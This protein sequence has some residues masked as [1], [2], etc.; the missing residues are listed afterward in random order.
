MANSR[1]RPGR[2]AERE[3]SSGV[4]SP[5]PPSGE[6]AVRG[7]SGR[8]LVPPARNG[9][10]LDLAGNL[11]PAFHRQT[12]WRQPCGAKAC[13]DQPGYPCMTCSNYWAGWERAQ[14]DGWHASISAAELQAR[15]NRPREVGAMIDLVCG[16][17]GKR[18]LDRLFANPDFPEAQTVWG[19]RYWC[20]N[21]RRPCAISGPG[22]LTSRAVARL[23]CRRSGVSGRGAPLPSGH[24]IPGGAVR[25]GMAAAARAAWG[26]VR[27]RVRG[28]AAPY[29]PRGGP[30]EAPDRQAYVLLPRSPLGPPWG[31][32]RAVSSGQPRCP[33]ESQIRS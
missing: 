1:E 28:W 17:C 8:A 6:A 14:P 16:G 18:S 32:D 2:L 33:T 23:R 4:T 26:S 3:A 12:E 20:G 7:S 10:G 13:W 25:C 22:G 31:R 5:P 27:A 15:L 11:Q 9:A 19:C 29:R 24:A 30:L 21:V